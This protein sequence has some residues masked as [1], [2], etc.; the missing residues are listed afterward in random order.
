MKTRDNLAVTCHPANPFCAPQYRDGFQDGNKKNWL[1]QRFYDVWGP[2]FVRLISNSKGVYAREEFGLFLAK[3]GV[4]FGL[5]FA[6]YV[7]ISNKFELF[8]LRPAS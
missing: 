6:Y 7:L 4:F 1:D 5:M 3:I 2:R 8:L